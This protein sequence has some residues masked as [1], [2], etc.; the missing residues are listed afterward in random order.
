MFKP[1][2]TNETAAINRRI[3]VMPTLTVVQRE[4]RRQKGQNLC[5]LIAT[6][7]INATLTAD[8][9]R[10]TIDTHLDRLPH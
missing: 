8:E 7:F 10:P 1:W 4:E 2:P 6:H 9:H 3:S 5:Q